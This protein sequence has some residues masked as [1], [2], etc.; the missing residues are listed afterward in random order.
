MLQLSSFS[1]KSLV[2]SSV[3]AR[4]SRFCGKTLDF[5]YNRDNFSQNSC[6][7]WCFLTENPRFPHKT[8]FQKL[9][10]E[11]LGAVYLKIQVHFSENRVFS[12]KFEARPCVSRTKAYKFLIKS[13]EIRKFVDPEFPEAFSEDFAL[14][15]R[16]KNSV[17]RVFSVFLSLAR[18]K[19]KN[20]CPSRDCLTL[21]RVSRE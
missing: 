10:I 9:I 4:I 5:P 12:L 2:F 15:Q 18:K 1:L 14:L 7:F 8:F 13:Q 11:N 16:L 17:F 19:P 3:F 21:I 20:L 6:G